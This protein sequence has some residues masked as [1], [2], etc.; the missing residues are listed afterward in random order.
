M[1]RR[2]RQVEDLDPHRR[3]GV[4]P[5]DSEG[6]LPDPSGDAPGVNAP[7]T[8][9]RSTIPT[10]TS[11]ASPTHYAFGVPDEPVDRILARLQAPRGS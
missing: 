4:P 3:T 8:A 7:A 1:G 9:S 2:Q 5:R 10:A 6:W 11:A